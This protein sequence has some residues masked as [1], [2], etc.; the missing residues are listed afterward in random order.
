MNGRPFSSSAPSRAADEADT[1]AAIATAPGAGAIGVIRLSGPRSRDVLEAVFRPSAPLFRGFIPRTL[2]HGRIVDARGADLDEALVVFFPGP[3]SFTGE[4]SAEIQGHGG[5]AVLQAVLQ[6]VLA[7]GARLAERGEFT[8]RAFLNGRLDLSQAEAVAE[9]VAAPSLE[10]VRLASAK[11][12]G[13][14]GRR[15]SELRDRLEYLRRKVCLAVDFPDEEAECLPPAEFL[16]VTGDVADG[17]RTLLAAYRRTRQWREG[18]L[19]VLAGRVNAGKSSLMNA[20]L[21][22]PRAIVTDQPGTTRDYLEEESCLDGLPV[23]LVD[24]AGLRADSG[25]PVEQEGMRRGRELAR[26]AQAV[27]LVLDGTLAA[28][29]PSA[30]GGRPDARPTAPPGEW[31]G[32]AAEKALLEAVGASRCLALW[33]KADLAPLPDTVTNFYGAPVLEVSARTGLGLDSL[34]A[35]ARSLCGAREPAPEEIAPNLRQ[36][37]ALEHALIELQ[38]L[39]GDIAAGVP[40][41]LCGL[42]LESA[43][44]HLAGITGL[45][46]AEDTLN[47]IFADFCIGK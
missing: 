9:L 28:R 23:R 38:D 7:R 41:D 16:A 2:H 8:R 3:R 14:L 30:P 17:V 32:F 44:A 27:L 25:D 31:E 10:G 24:T 34:A 15:V 20:L 42:R 46:S 43:A 21:G 36:A 37:R 22:R 6:A 5:T 11:L 18:A 12:H 40:P 35:A 19:V 39:E 1:I 29:A 4:D 13:L 45:N 26:A 47:S 33:N